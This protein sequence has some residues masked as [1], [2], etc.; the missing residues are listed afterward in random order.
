[1][2]TSEQIHAALQLGD[3]LYRAE[4]F[5]PLYHE[6]DADGMASILEQV[7]RGLGEAELT[8]WIRAGEEWREKHPPFK[9]LPRLRVRGHCFEQETGQRFTAIEASDFNLFARFQNGEDITPVLQQRRD[10]GYNMRRVWTL[11]DIPSIGTL[12]HPDYGRM[13]EFLVLCAQYG[14]YVEFTA[15]TSTFDPNHW[16]R[17]IEAVRGQSNVLLEL[18]N[19]LDLPVNR[20]IDLDFYTKPDGILCSHG[21]NSSQAWPVIPYW[22]YATFHTNGAREEQRK[23]G[24]NAWEI[25]SGAVLTNETSRWP[26]VGMWP[27]ATLERAQA[28]AF[29]SAAGAALLC[30][31]S[32]FHSIHGKTSMLWTWPEVE[33]ATAWANG[34]RSVDL[35]QQDEAYQHRSDL[36]GPDDLRVYQRGAAIVKIRK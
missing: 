33:V 3:R 6:A 4:L 34:A 2:L 26:D 28:L 22:D 20:L 13:A 7:S 17:L 35:T 24:H 12:L 25:G 30:A 36:E 14:S 9:P 1:M 15:Y 10:L 29:D 23:I 16:G 11:Y 27:H 31:G 5:R 21:S 32:C 8:A 19:E 18:G